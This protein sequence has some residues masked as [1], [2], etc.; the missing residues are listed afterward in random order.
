MT[1]LLPIRWHPV[2]LVVI[3]AVLLGQFRLVRE[4]RR[5]R[6]AVYALVSLAMVTLWP[7]G[8]LAASVSLTVATV[9]RL[10]IMLLV[11][12]L[13]LLSLP[14]AALVRLTRPQ[15]VDAVVHRITHPGLA[16]ALVTVVGTVTLMTPAV[17]WGARS[18]FG[19]DV[20]L[21]TTL[22]TGLV[23]WMPALAI[24]PGTRHLSPIAR[25]AYVFVAALVVTSLSFVWIFSTHSLYP[26]L[27][28]QH[29]ILHVTPLFDQQ[30]AGFVAKLGAYIP[31]WAVSFTIFS[32]ADDR[33][34]PVEETPLHWADVEREMLRVDRRRARAQRRRSHSA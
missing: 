34:A 17:D 12:P 27:H 21:L 16:M 2:E 8:D 20:V 3:T 1:S 11:A 18:T 30:L 24:M 33:G 9:Q 6:L 25:A 19:R 23:L 29:A 14:T 32:R 31:M 22:A 15:A 28:G 5:R 13:L 10:V 26:G 7:I 4:P